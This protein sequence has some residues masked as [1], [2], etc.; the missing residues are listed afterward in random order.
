[1]IPANGGAAI[2][3]GAIVH[4]KGPRE[5]EEAE[6]QL[7]DDG[8][9]AGGKV[10]AARTH[11]FEMN[12]G[13]EVW[14]N[15]AAGE[16]RVVVAGLGCSRAFRVDDRVWVDAFRV[17][18]AG[19]HN[20]RAGVELDGRYGYARPRTL[21]PADGFTVYQSK[22]PI[23]VTGEGVSG[24]PIDYRLGATEYLTDE[25]RPNAW[26]GLMDAG[27]WDR[28]TQHLGVVYELFNLHDQFPTYFGAF[29]LNLPDTAAA[30]PDPLYAELKGADDLPDVLAEAVFTLDFFRRMQSPDGGVSG[31]VEE[32]FTDGRKE[33]SGETATSWTTAETPFAYAPDAWTTYQYAATAAR[34]AGAFAALGMKTWRPS[35]ATA[36]TGRGGGRRGAATRR[37]WLPSSINTS[38][39]A[40]R[41]SGG[42]AAPPRTKPSPASPRRPPPPAPGPRR[43]GGASR[44]GRPIAAS[45]SM[46]PTSSPRAGRPPR[47]VCSPARCGRSSATPPPTRSL[48]RTAWARCAARRRS[49]AW[50]L[51]S[52]WRSGSSS[53]PSPN[54]STGPA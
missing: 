4:R 53:T 38:P 23:V 17:G 49:T 20:H 48:R 15:P 51:N 12:F 32:F 13:P 47:T 21:H 25:P 35:I 18:M 10:N 24:V 36:A 3:S 6:W 34:A 50:T 45:C 22:L 54:T 30:L 26:G 11:V 31:G 33:G 8:T 40:T 28:R 41:R 14:P 46:P 52:G 39:P 37:N 42:N 16:Y 29:G 1:M 7:F 27:D 44:G 19:L 43:N 5:P 9:G 2:A